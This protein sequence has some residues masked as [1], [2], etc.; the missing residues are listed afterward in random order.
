MDGYPH[1]PGFLSWRAVGKV[2]AVRIA[3]ET[4]S[5]GELDDDWELYSIVKSV[6]VD[7][8][9][10]SLM[11]LTPSLVA[12]YSQWSANCVSPWMN[13]SPEYESLLATTGNLCAGKCKESSMQY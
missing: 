2:F 7:M 6:D 3:T 9:M 11:S 13:R 5:L 10:M 4:C 1:A 12:R 8:A